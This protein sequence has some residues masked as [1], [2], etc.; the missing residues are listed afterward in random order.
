MNAL[1]KRLAALEQA[2]PSAMPRWH[3]L[4]RYE[5]ESE[6]DAIAAY[7]AEHGPIGDGNVIMRVIISKPGTRLGS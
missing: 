3:C 1:G 6:A 4:R 5:D 2:Q 7:E